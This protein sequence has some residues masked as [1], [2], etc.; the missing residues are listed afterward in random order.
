MSEHRNALRNE[1]SPYLLQHADN[2][3]NWN[4]WGEDAL[5][6]ARDLNKP[7]LLS[8]GYSAC[9]WCHV[10]AHESF[11]D[12]E[13]ANLMNEL[14]V[15]IKVDREERP[16]LDKIYQTAHQLLTRRPGGW[17]LTMFLMPD[18]H[19]P[20][21]GGTYFPPDA[22]FGLPG[23]KELLI[24][25]D[26]L[27]RERLDDIRTQNHSLMEALNN[28]QKTTPGSKASLN[29]IPLQMARNQA[30]QSFDREHGGFG[31][32]PKFPHPPSIERLLRDFAA[33]R[34]A[35]EPDQEA[36]EMAVFSLTKMALGGIY[37]QL[38]GGFC[39]YS[40]DQ[41]W[42]IPHFE[43]MLYDNGPLLTLYSHAWQ[44][45]HNDLFKKTALEIAD[46][47][48]RDMQSSEG[49]FYSSLDADSE[50]E[51]G[52]FYVWT[53]AEVNALVDEQQYQ[54]I[55]KVFGLDQPANFEGKWNLHALNPLST[56][57]QAL[58]L[59]ID[60][61]S[62]KLDAAR[63]VLLAER[64][65][66]I[67]PG[68]DEKVLTSWNALMIKGLAVSARIF[69]RPDHLEAAYRALDFIQTT[70][71]TGERLLAT[72]KDGKAHLNAYLDDYAF[73]IDALLAC[74]ET[75]WRSA[76][77][78]FAIALADTMLARFEDEDGGFF[79]T[80]HDH[81]TLIQR[82]KSL[83]DD[84]L[85]AGNGVAAH[86]LLRLGHILGDVTYL[87]SA[88]RTLLCAWD[89][90]SQTPSA[91]NTMLLALEEY[92]EPTETLILR[93]PN[94]VLAEWQRRCGEDY[95]PTRQT[96]AVP[97][98]AEN[99]PGLLAERHSVDGGVAYL[100]RGHQCDAPLTNIDALKDTLQGY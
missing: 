80:S 52:K 57:A 13:T 43:K 49:G 15:N 65:K 81:E 4:P 21:F 74:V 62:N 97:G 90:I 58:S 44:L 78:N 54:L 76:D 63:A 50:G 77:L 69:E 10:M 33:S 93:G 48:V 1:T 64:N 18:D 8:V 7:I 27:F 53:R 95:A 73:L 9:H 17:P 79:F 35:D 23:F 12:T 40:V 46:W 84:A 59:D 19:A 99:L 68:R 70:M 61:A 75:H 31:D 6:E 71:W 32:A 82:S 5:G 96:L 92:L 66:R 47:V 37:D 55:S 24:R 91:C 3:V 25:V 60:E 11:E 94:K 2:P 88:E 89:S 98:D 36:F 30:A 14:F 28:L 20:F 42:T 26:E 87:E 22:R 72:W 45:T 56:A 86:S 41:H 51:E 67:W 16:D 100:C 38:G 85:P 83:S 29:H 34:A 39:R